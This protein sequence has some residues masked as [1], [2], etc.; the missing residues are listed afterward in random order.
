MAKGREKL[1]FASNTALWMTMAFCLLG[2]QEI[3]A[4]GKESSVATILVREFHTSI[5]ASLPKIQYLILSDANFTGRLPSQFGNLSNLLSL[6]LSAIHW[7]QA[8]NKL[9]SLIHLNL[10]HCSLPPLTTP[11]LSPVNFSAPLAFLDLSWNDLTS[12]IYSWLFNFP[13]TLIHFDLSLNAD[14]NGSIPEAFGNMSSLEYLDISQN[15]L[16]GSIPDAFGNMSSLTYF[17]LSSN[18]L[19]GSIPD[20]VGNM[21]SLEELYL[22]DNKLEGEIPKSLS[23]LCH[24]QK[25]ALQSNNLSGQLPQD[26]LAC[27]NDTLEILYLS[28][29]Q[30]TGSVPDLIGFSSLRVLYLG[31]NQLNGTLP[32]SIG[33]LTKLQWL[34]I[35]SNSLQGV[36]SEA[37]L[38]HLSDLHTL[39]LSSNSLTF[40]MSLEWVPPFQLFSLALTSCQLGPHFPSWLRTQ[41]S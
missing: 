9:P 16:Q 35:G 29:N 23:N 37:H 2:T 7:S 28:Y 5:P 36:I 30:F 4:N 10:R 15:Q 8:I 22:H 13:T 32:T 14:L 11:S 41:S 21:A 25:L 38:F 18:Q 33:H 27:A 19:Q 3:V 34:D 26:L 24:L 31:Y 39:D 6:D 40:N 1:C 20:T 12:S 17:D